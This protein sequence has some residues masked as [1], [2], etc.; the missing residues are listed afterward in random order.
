MSYIQSLPFRFHTVR[1]AT[2]PARGASYRYSLGS[3]AD[4]DVPKEI[5]CSASGIWSSIP[6]GEDLAAYMEAYSRLFA[7]GL[8]DAV[9][10]GFFAWVEPY[11]F[12]GSD[13]RGTTVSAPVYDRSVD[14]PLF[15]G[16][17]GVDFTIE[18]MEEAVGGTN[19]YDDVLASLVAKS[20]AT[21]PNLDLSE[22]VI[23][24]L[25]ELSGGATCAGECA[26]GTVNIVPEACLT[27]SDYP[28]FLWA[29]TDD[30]NIDY[31]EKACCTPGSATPAEASKTCKD[32][33]S[34]DDAT[35]RIIGLVLGFGISAGFM[36]C[37]YFYFF[38]RQSKPPSQPHA[39]PSAR[40]AQAT[41]S[42]AEVEVET[43]EHAR[44]PVI[45][46]T[47]VSSGNGVARIMVPETR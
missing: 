22:C 7:M 8:G 11:E 31:V 33:K 13:G 30:R 32:E 14:P 25:R 47:V 24:A 19:A 40:P 20:T 41:A 1:S 27:S 6:D 46:G 18:A 44:P 34:I 4:E 17:C 10:E 16:V 29:N 28:S 26:A 12:S 42:V 37:L 45:T 21:C 39:V 36:G 43:F 35:A 9:N 2:K 3:G 38:R 15:L 23:Q 5:A